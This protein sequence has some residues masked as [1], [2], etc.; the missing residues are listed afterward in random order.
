MLKAHLDAVESTLIATSQIPA[1][2]GHMLHRGTPRESFIK[3]FLEGHIST[4]VSIG[5]GE[6]IDASSTPRQ[7]RNQFDIVVYRN[8]YP[9][10][11]LGGGINAFLAES[12]I[13]TIEVKS[14][15]TAADLST[16]IKNANNVK[17]LQQNIITTFTSG[18]IPP[19]ILS[20]VVSYGGPANISTVYGWLK[21]AEQTHG[22][23]LNNLPPTGD[24]R[25]KAISE[26]I[27]GIFCLQ[28]GSIIFDNSPLSML[29]DQ[30][31]QSLPRGKFSVFDQADGNVFWLFMLLT[32]AVSGVSA[33]WANLIPYVNRVHMQ[34]QFL[35]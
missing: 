12:V 15:L 6:I 27:E 24:D 29:N 3:Q 4:R 14:L 2:A 26:S 32:Q 13:A 31:R 19:G 8:D 20:Y 11:D 25:I 22:L 18:Y 21:Q 35:P 1:N 9:R 33:Q 7:P 16:A 10:I 17:T 23:N 5:T 28:I 34:S 30:L